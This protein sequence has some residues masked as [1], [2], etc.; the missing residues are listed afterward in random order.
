MENDQY[1]VQQVSRYGDC[2]FS[3][4]TQI[5]VQIAFPPSIQG[6]D[7]VSEEP[8]DSASPSSALSYQGSAMSRPVKAGSHDHNLS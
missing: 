4:T 7:N 8:S 1:A 2:F 6:N 3:L 5:H